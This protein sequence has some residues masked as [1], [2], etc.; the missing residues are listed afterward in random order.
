MVE[1]CRFADLL[2]IHNLSFD[3]CVCVYVCVLSVCFGGFTGVHFLTCFCVYLSV[4]LKHFK[5]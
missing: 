3:V 1:F 2:S 5:T 4:T